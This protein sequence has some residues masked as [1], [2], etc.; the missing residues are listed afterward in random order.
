MI[1]VL[2][3]MLLVMFDESESLLHVMLHVM[4]LVMLLVM[5]HEHHTVNSHGMAFTEVK[6]YNST[7]QIEIYY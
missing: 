4:L 7:A 3:V 6:N 1:R 5:L 2:H